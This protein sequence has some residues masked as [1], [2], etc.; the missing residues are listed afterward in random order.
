MADSKILEKDIVGA[1]CIHPECIRLSL[2]RSLERLQIPVVS[3]SECRSL[4]DK[5]SLTL[6]L[7]MSDCDVC[8]DLCV[9]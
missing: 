5:Q 2:E 8:V 9:G 7:S 6:H 3:L 4:L 1:N